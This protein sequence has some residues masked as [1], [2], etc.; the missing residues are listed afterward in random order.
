MTTMK[1]VLLALSTLLAVGGA[2]ARE[3]DVGVSVQIGQPGFYGRIDIGDAPRPRLIYA[4]PMLVHRAPRVVYE[5]VYLRVPPGHERHWHKHCH[6]YEACGRP[7]Y[8]VRDDW[9]Q[10]VYVPHYQHRHSE[11]RHDRRDDWRDGRRDDW[12]DERGHGHRHGHG[13]G[14][15]HGRD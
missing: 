2:L 10:G 14:H 8:F 7:V 11:H 3:V 12:R 4:E 13:R 6:R 5:P 1:R 15:G 9:Y